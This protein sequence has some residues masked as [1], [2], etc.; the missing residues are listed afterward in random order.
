[1]FSMVMLIKSVHDLVKVEKSPQIYTGNAKQL[2]NA[3]Y[4]FKVKYL[5]VFYLPVHN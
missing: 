4:L 1:M 2:F 5:V 3:H